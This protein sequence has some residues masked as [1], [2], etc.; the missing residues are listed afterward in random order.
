MGLNSDVLVYADD[1]GNVHGTV[2]DEN[3]APLEEVKIT[4]YSS[5]GGLDTA[6][7]NGSGYFRLALKEGR[8]T[9][10]FTKEGYST[11]TKDITVPQEMWE[12]PDYDPVKMGEIVLEPALQMHTKYLVVSE[13]LGEDIE[14]PLT[15]TNGGEGDEIIELQSIVPDGWSISFFTSKDLA[16]KKLRLGSKDSEE[17]TIRIEPSGDASIGDYDVI[18][19]ALTEDNMINAS[20]KLE[21][22]LSEASYDVEIISTFKD[23]TAKA[24]ESFNFP[25]TIWNRGGRDALMLLTVASSPENWETVFVSDDTEISNF[26]VKEGQS[27]DLHL[28]VTPPSTVKTGDYK[29]VFNAESDDGLIQE[30]TELTASIVGS[31]DVRLEL[32]TLY[33][34]LKIGDSVEFTARVTNQGS[35][36]I[37]TIYVEADVPEDWETT[38][39]PAQTS[40]LTSRES[41][42]F[43]ITADTPVDT[44]AGDYLITVQAMSDQAESDEV[45][46]RVTAQASTSWGFIGVGVVG[47][48]IIGLV[49]V[50]WRYKR[51]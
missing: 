8:Y 4:I 1:K 3:G 5:S 26:L 44:V 14:L 15:I 36:P 37:T 51:R 9:V 17:L 7:T 23:I 41:V 18:I 33:E 13:E 31:Y 29:I 49:F 34:T 12:D 30:N 21:V 2:L 10:E 39:T 6:Y 24:G 48:V 40:T 16:V 25:I 45:D 43:T 50:F 47:V 46:L 38:T 20:L 27:I 22:N 42:T 11:V 32:S 28:E 35:S 19:N